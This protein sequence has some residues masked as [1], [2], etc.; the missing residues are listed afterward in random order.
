MK[1]SQ[2][3]CGNLV[4]RVSLLPDKAFGGEK[5]DPGNEVGSA[6]VKREG[7]GVEENI[8]VRHYFNQSI[9]QSLFH[10]HNKVTSN[11]KQN[12]FRFKVTGVQQQA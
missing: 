12:H 7:V 8:F 11:N 9:N 10:F 3:K 4:P 5:R 6:G 1:R 2:K